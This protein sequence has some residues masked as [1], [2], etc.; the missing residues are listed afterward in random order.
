MLYVAIAMGALEFSKIITASYLYRYWKV[1]GFGLKTYLTIA[2]LVLMIVTSGGIYG[3]LTNSYQGATVGL[4]KINS[5]TQVLEQRK[6]NLND[7]RE[8][9]KSDIASL[10]AERQSTI[11][12]RN[13]EI[14]ANN[15]LTDSNSVK[16]R[17][18]RNS[19]VKKRYEPELL[20][21]DNQVAKYTVD[22]DSTNVRLSRINDEIA[23]KSLEMIDTGIDVGPLVYMARIFNT[24]MDAVMKW[25]T[26]VIVGVFDPLAIALIIAYNA[27]IMRGKQEKQYDI[28][29]DVALPGDYSITSNDETFD[30]GEPDDLSGV[31]FDG[32]NFPN[33][34][35]IGA[36][37]VEQAFDDIKVKIEEKKRPRFSKPNP[38]KE[39]PDL[40]KPLDN[41]VEEIKEKPTK[42]LSNLEDEPEKTFIVN[43][44]NDPKKIDEAIKKT[45]DS[46]KSTER[47][48]LEPAKSGD[49]PKEKI[50]E[51]VKKVKHQ[52]EFFDKMREEK[53]SPVTEDEIRNYFD[54]A[55]RKVKK[56]DQGK[57]TRTP[58]QAG[59][60]V[61]VGHI[62]DDPDIDY[63]V[64]E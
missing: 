56:E 16:Y 57:I 11:I 64:Q 63:S 1:T 33:A 26:L 35:I 31:T 23:D 10:R 2:L 24:S 7:E 61:N 53:K 30:L 19:Q 45:I 52:N 6:L 41:L 46:I 29:V 34:T 59:G 4:D 15:L 60:N 51:A 20:N 58:F 17:S 25:F 38:K 49:I 55:I 36:K 48:V 27:I 28:G 39:V 13:N 42:E 62:E 9:L 12:N 14:T 47:V 22:L 8:R 50:I 5:Q 43:V 21:I 37:P 3:Y 32:V 18:W 44:D 40:I 54:D